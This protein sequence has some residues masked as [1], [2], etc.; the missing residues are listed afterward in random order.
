[1]D[2]AELLTRHSR[3]FQKVFLCNSGTEAN[4]GAL[5]FAR[6]AHMLAAGLVLFS[7]TALVLVYVLD[8]R[9]VRGAR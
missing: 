4:E 8:R 1:L 7:F 6:K 3:H 9:A 2:V 5:K